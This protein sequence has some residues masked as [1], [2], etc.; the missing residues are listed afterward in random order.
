[1]PVPEGLD[2]RTVGEYMV[3]VDVRQTAWGEITHLEIARRDNL[4]VH[5]WYDLLNVKDEVCGEERVAV[6]VYPARSRLVDAQHA[7]HLWVL[8]EG[9][10]LPFG[11]HEDD[12]RDGQT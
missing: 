4:P 3:A 7:Y 10:V 6:E 5:K 2:L 12:N 8:P 1:M 9:F 11:I